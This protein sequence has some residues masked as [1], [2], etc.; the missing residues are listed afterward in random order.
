MQKSKYVLQE[1][2]YFQGKTLQISS[3]VLLGTLTNQ[4]QKT[5]TASPPQPEK[6]HDWATTASKKQQITGSL[7][8]KAP[9]DCAPGFRDKLCEK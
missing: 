4:L 6:A 5:T 8:T 2:F 3:A 1:A 9:N 7:I